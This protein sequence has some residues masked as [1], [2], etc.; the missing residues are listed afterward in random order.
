MTVTPFGPSCSWRSPRCGIITT[1]GPHQVAQN[2]TTY[3]FPFSNALTSVPANHLVAFSG[4]G[5][6]PSLRVDCSL[7]GFGSSAADSQ[8]LPKA[9]ARV[10]S[11]V[12]IGDTF[13]AG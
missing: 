13:G 5:A 9:K 11:R 1:H 10:R 8:E 6:S 12:R 3:T 7:A 4:G 2:S